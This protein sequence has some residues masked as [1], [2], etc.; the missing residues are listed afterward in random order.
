VKWPRALIL[1]M[2]VTVAATL[3]LSLVFGGRAFALLL[4]LPV[5]FLFRRPRED[6]PAPPRPAAARSSHANPVSG[7]TGF[8]CMLR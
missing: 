4:I 7:R 1:S 2:A 5:G 8:H 6:H 3:A